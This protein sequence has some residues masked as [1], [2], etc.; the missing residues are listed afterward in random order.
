MKMKFWNGRLYF[1]VS[2]RLESPWCAVIRRLEQARTFT[3]GRVAVGRVVLGPPRSA[4]PPLSHVREPR[5]SPRPR[6]PRRAQAA[7][8]RD[9][10]GERDDGGGGDG[11]GDGGGG[12]PP[13]PAHGDAGRWPS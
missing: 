6:T 2:P 9:G 8:G 12:D 1:G 10:D 11:D 5:S 7:S 3:V 4:A 13:G